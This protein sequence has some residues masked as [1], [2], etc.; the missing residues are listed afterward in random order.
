MNAILK[1]TTK[2]LLLL[3]YTLVVNISLANSNPCGIK[4]QFTNQKDTIVTGNLFQ[5]NFENISTGATSIKWLYNGLQQFYGPTQPSN[6]NFSIN[7]T[8]A[9]GIHK[10][11]LVISNGICF[12]TAT[13]IVILT[14]TLPP[15]TLKNFTTSLSVFSK[16]YNETFDHIITDF[17]RSDSNNYII[18]GSFT[19]YLNGDR[20][21]PVGYLMKISDSACIKWTK[22][23]E[24]NSNVSALKSCKNGDILAI[25]NWGQQSSKPGLIKLSSDGQIKWSLTLSNLA[26]PNEASPLSVIAEDENEN[27]IIAGNTNNYSTIGKYNT[28]QKVIKVDKNG[29]IVWS[30]IFR[31]KYINPNGT[32]IISKH[33]LTVGNDIYLSGIF[34]IDGS[35]RL[36][37]FIAKLDGSNGNEIWSK[38]FSGI[39][40]ENFLLTDLHWTGDK[41]LANFNMYSV[42]GGT[43]V[44]PIYSYINTDGNLLQSHQINITDFK[45]IGPFSFKILPIP[46]GGLYY[47]FYG[48]EQLPVQP[49]FIYYSF[50][51][52]IS[53]TNNIDW[54]WKFGNYTRDYY[55]HIALGKDSSLLALGSGLV[56]VYKFFPTQNILYTKF[57]NNGTLSN[58]CNFTKSNYTTQPI[59]IGSNT[60]SWQEDSTVTYF[61]TNNKE[62]SLGNIN[63]IKK[64]LCPSYIDSCSYISIEGETKICD[65]SKNYTYKIQSL[66]TCNFQVIKPTEITLINT[67]DTSIT[68]SFNV[69]GN[70]TIKVEKMNGCSPIFDIITVNAKPQI[71]SI[72]LGPDTAVCNGSRIK[73]NAGKQFLKYMWQDGSSDSILYV[74]TP[75]KYYVTVID[76]C[77]RA[78]SDTINV[79]QASTAHIDYMPDIALCSGDSAVLQA[80]MGYTNYTWIQKDYSSFLDTARLKIKP[81]ISYTYIVTAVDANGCV[82]NDSAK[83]TVNELPKTFLP[84]DTTLCEGTSLLLNTSPNFKN[85]L[86]STGVTLPAITITKNGKYWLTVEG[87]NGCKQRDTTNVSFQPIPKFS[88]GKDTTLCENNTYLLKTDSTGTYLWQDGSSQNSLL[89]ASPGVY[90]LTINRGSCVF[91]DTVIISYQKNP[92]LVFP[93]DTILCD[94]RT[95]FL[96]PTPAGTI[97]TYEWQDG[98]NKSSYTITK[99]GRYSVLV[100]AVGCYST[101]TV[102]VDYQ[103]T[104]QVSTKDLTKCIEDTLLFDAF[105]KGASYLW[106][107]LSKGPTFTI[108]QPGTYRCEVTNFCG[109][110]LN[111]LQVTNIICS[112]DIIA[113]NIFS[114]NGDG[115]NDIFK[116]S[117]GCQLSFFDMQVFN[118]NGQI[119]F[120]SSD[121]SN[122][123][124]GTMNGKSLPVGTYYY[125]I[126]VKG[127]FDQ[128]VKQKTGSITLLK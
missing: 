62:A 98:S 22:I 64:W 75:G 59:T 24:G 113:P 56:S 32:G 26:R 38:Q 85:Y 52:K 29:I 92:K 120:K 9:V 114:P 118:R 126:K 1:V 12:D 99:P 35:P 123:W 16:N 91:S 87:Q 69:P 90:W 76:S 72:N 63:A 42:S 95:L 10:I 4:A 67:T 7:T 21:P 44:I 128:T 122:E 106:Q 40:S 45:M 11:Q 74:T 49:G 19:T 127:Q 117:T 65:L 47:S 43:T 107:D 2:V 124:N 17:I 41:L 34:N 73:L 23:L 37:S 54:Q 70:Y 84:K 46:G 8:N 108:T 116:I 14:G 89:V 48:N 57:E 97:A 81:P 77:N 121:I 109:T 104:P 111:T 68:V 31:K 82:I 66:G 86:W 61:K 88:L 25:A 13:A 103:P 28:E 115:I 71:Y 102:L 79:T 36:E 3:I 94:N 78:L 55:T 80:K 51:A 53:A 101:D 27:I 83:I 96:N 100:K 5:A 93:N 15:V 20:L 18:S 60:F 105:T 39:T 119:V 33:I 125:I 6:F 58:P 110:A 50:F 112:C 30:K